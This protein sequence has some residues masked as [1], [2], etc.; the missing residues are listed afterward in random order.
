V[1]CCRHTHTH[2]HTHTQAHTHTH[3]TTTTD[4]PTTGVAPS[5][6][7]FMAFY[8]PVKHWVYANTPEDR[9]AGVARARAQGGCWCVAAL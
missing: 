8:E 9:C 6:A 2:T 1:C 7:I 5:S 3:T 4:T